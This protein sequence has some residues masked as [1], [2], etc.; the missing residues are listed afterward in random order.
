MGLA[1]EE[2]AEELIFRLLTWI[3]SQ[4]VFVCCSSYTIFIGRGNEMVHLIVSM[5]VW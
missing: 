3:I 2:F 1:C 4:V 5:I